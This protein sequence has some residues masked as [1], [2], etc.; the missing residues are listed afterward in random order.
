MKMDLFMP[1]HKKK[2]KDAMEE[3]GFQK[4]EIFLVQFSFILKKIIQ[5]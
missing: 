5:V 1:C 4:K 3:D 2:E